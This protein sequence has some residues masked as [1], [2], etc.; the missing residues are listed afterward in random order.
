MQPFHLLMSFVVNG[1]LFFSRVIE[2]IFSEVD[3][4][5]ELGALIS[6]FKMSALPSLYDHFVKLISYL[7]KITL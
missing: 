4:Q 1:F 6:E 7:V 3:K 2:M 5:I